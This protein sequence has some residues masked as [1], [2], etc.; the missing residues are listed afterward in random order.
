MGLFGWLLGKSTRKPAGLSTTSQ[1]Q[2]GLAYL[3]RGWDYLEKGEW[4]KAMADFNEA[5]RLQ[6]DFAEAYCNRGFAYGRKG[7]WDKAAADYT[8]SLR[9]NPNQIAAYGNR[10][11]AHGQRGEFDKAIADFTEVIRLNPAHPLSYFQRGG[12]YLDKHEWDKAIAEFNEAIRLNFDSPALVYL[13]RGI[14]YQLMGDLDK[15]ISDCNKAI[16]LDPDLA[17]A[18]RLRD[19]VYGQLAKAKAGPVQ[20][21]KVT[22]P[23]PEETNPEVVGY[24]TDNQGE[25]HPVYRGSVKHEALSPEQLQ[26]VARLRGVLADVNPPTMDEWVNAFQRDLDPES[27]IRLVEA[28]AVVY[29]RLIAQVDL[30]P[31]EKSRLWVVLSAVS[32]GGR[33][34]ELSAMIPAGKGLPPLESI[35]RLYQE[36]CRGG[37]R[38]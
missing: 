16:H 14:A 20:R 38:P 15:A 8:E 4:D 31:D 18:H 35:V 12:V 21:L 33:G 2:D 26:R 19:S 24:Y 30:S 13:H 34:P 28:S 37:S 5:I 7:D 23:G 6:P 9:L 3:H 10:G 29:A 1:S 25:R 32:L 17:E 11:I 36:A 27:E 22:L